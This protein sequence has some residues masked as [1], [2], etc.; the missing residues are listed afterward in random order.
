M[1]LLYIDIKLTNHVNKRPFAFVHLISKES[2]CKIAF[3]TDMNKERDFR[4]A[5]HTDFKT[6]I[7]TPWIGNSNVKYDVCLFIYFI[8]QTRT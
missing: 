7:T 6:F 3:L 4:I 8:M 1:F 2:D 5:F